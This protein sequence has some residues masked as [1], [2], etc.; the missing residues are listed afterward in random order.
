MSEFYAFEALPL[1]WVT[2]D[3]P[4][5]ECQSVG[6]TETDSRVFIFGKDTG[7][8]L[9]LSS[10]F[11]GRAETRNPLNDQVGLREGPCLIEAAYV[12]F[13]SQWDPPGF[14]AKDLLLNKLDNGVVDSDG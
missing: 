14:R 10:L 7:Q 8:I 4:F 12:D 6:S 13:T 1:N 5:S 2:H 9:D 11:L 3:G